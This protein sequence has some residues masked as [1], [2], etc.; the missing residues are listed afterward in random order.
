MTEAMNETQIDKY[1]EHTKLKAISPTSQQ[2]GQFLE[3]LQ[4]GQ[5][6]DE[7]GERHPITLCTL[8]DFKD[9]EDFDAYPRE[10]YMPHRESIQAIL[11]RYY[12]IDL[13]VIEQEKRAML[14]E[15]RAQPEGEANNG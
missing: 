7:E 13:K 12:D 14:A 1:P 11:A 8:V 15:L 6:E 5:P 4:D 2:I 9:T 10:Q 3:W